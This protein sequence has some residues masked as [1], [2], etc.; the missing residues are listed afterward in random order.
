MNEKLA[1]LCYCPAHVGESEAFLK[2]LDNFPPKHDLIMYSDTLEREGCI[3]LGGSIDVAETPKNKMSK[4]NLIFLVGIRIAASQGFTHVLILEPD[5][6]VNRR[7]WDSV[8]FDE[9]FAKNPMAVCG[10]SMVIFNPSSHNQNAARKFEKLVADNIESPMPFAIT[11]TGNLAEHRDS[12]VFPNGALAIYNVSW[13]VK[14]FPEIAGTPE[15][16]IERAQNMK[17]FDYEVGIRMWTEFKEDVYD[18]VVHFHS[19]YSGYGNILSSEDERKELL[20]SGKVV[21][22]HQIKSDWTGPEKKPE[23]DLAPVIQWEDKN[24]IYQIDRRVLAQD[25]VVHVRSN[26]KVEILIV[27]Y[28]KDFPYLKYCLKSIAKFATEFLGVTIL[29]PKESLEECKLIVKEASEIFKVLPRP[30]W[31][32]KGMLV[33]MIAKCRADEYTTADYI[34]HMDADCIFNAPITPET[35]FKDGKPI[36]QFEKLETLIEREPG[37]IAWKGAVENCLPIKMEFE[38]MRQHPECYHR[39][40][41]KLMREMV[42]KH[43]GKDFDSYVR[44]QRNEHP[45]GFCEFNTLGNVALQFQKELYNPID[46]GGNSNPNGGLFP[47]YQMW[48]HSPIDKEQETWINGQKVKVVPIQLIESILGK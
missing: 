16:Y 10:G 42:E 48:S 14:T 46:N 41:Y 30:D 38:T 1:V 22:V 19:V 39:S 43:T 40:T 8:I 4:P 21:A 12:C 32:V 35:L 25:L 34:A 37:V 27:T 44:A 36:L 45:P 5:C 17:T 33:H 26:P 18:K 7:H 15:K 31:K 24:T 3:K 6:R 2:N 23:I 28:C 29:V 20:T 9:F 47:L 13:L 11:G